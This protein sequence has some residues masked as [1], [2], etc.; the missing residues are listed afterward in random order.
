MEYTVDISGKDY[1]LE[2][3]AEGAAN[4]VYKLRPSHS[5]LLRLRKTRSSIPYS[6]IVHNF[7]TIVAPL[8]PNDALIHPRLFKL[9][10]AETLISRLNEALR[11]KDADGSRSEMRKGVYL[12]TDEEHG[13]FIHDM[14]PRHQKE[15]FIEFKPKWLIQ[16]PSAP[17][18]A[19]R[20][21]TC[22]LREMR[23]AGNRASGRGD[24]GFCPLDLLSTTEDMLE[25]VLRSLVGDDLGLAK[26]I[27][28]DKVQ[29]LLV[30][31]RTLQI[32]HNR[33][34][35]AGLNSERI[36][37]PSHREADR[38]QESSAASVMLD[39]LLGMTVRDCS[40]FIRYNT[41]SS[42]IE[43]DVKLADL[44]MKSAKLEKWADIERQLI[45]GGWYTGTDDGVEERGW[46][47]CRAL[48]RS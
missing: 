24:T 20:C 9:P 42:E 28:K 44:D 12:A 43:A 32:E 18:E 36:S 11:E 15:K 19:K 7:E 31:L 17:A 39:T 23:R 40:V 26:A 29:P 35:L 34:G 48:Q 46:R 6:E 10:D 47:L 33:V 45:D 4:I 1:A 16:S 8:F 14:T 38:S 21:R 25:D 3:L 30:R 27:F 2:Y 37:V 22:A 41:G 5:D 13:I